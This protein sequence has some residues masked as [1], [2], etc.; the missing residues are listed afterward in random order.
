MAIFFFFFLSFGI[1][2]PEHFKVIRAI[3]VGEGQPGPSVQ[4]DSLTKIKAETENLNY[5]HGRFLPFE[6]EKKNPTG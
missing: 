3:R 6:G 5:K 4:A 2:N 1:K